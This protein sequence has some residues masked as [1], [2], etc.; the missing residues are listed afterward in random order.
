MDLLDI[1][2]IRL[3][4]LIMVAAFLLFYLLYSFFAIYHAVKYGF[5]GDKLTYPVLLIFLAGSAALIV[6][7]LLG[8]RLS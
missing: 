4:L 1:E 8:L 7:T 2:T 5:R 3:L 6:F